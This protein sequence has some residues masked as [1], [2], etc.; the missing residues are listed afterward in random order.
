MFEDIQNTEDDL[1][2]IARKWGKILDEDF[3][4]KEVLS[5]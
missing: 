1:L 2:T 4:F 5:K 3:A